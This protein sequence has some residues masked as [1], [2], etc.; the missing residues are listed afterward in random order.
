MSPATRSIAARLL[1]LSPWLALL[2]LCS[3]LFCWTAPGRIGYPDDEIVFQTTQSLVEQHSVEV[4]GIDKRTG[5]REG[6]PTGT[7]GWAPGRDGRRYGFFGQA[8]SVV[9][10]PMYLLADAT[11]DDIDERWRYAIRSDLFTFHKRSP[12]ADWLRLV[13]SLS[14]SLITPLGA[15]LLGLW[16]RALGHGPRASILTALCYALGTTA[17]PY[18]GSFLSE[19]LSV[20]VLLG[21]A[22]TI[23]RW[24]RDGR[25]PQL[26]LAGALAGLS[27]HV[28]VLNLITLPCLIGYALAP[29]LRA[30]GLR[31]VWRALD[32]RAWLGAT[33]ACVVGLALL[34]VSQWWRFGS[35]FETG[36]YDHYGHWVWPWRG[37]FT[38][39]VAPGRSL[40]IYSP[41]LLLGLAAW[42]ALRRRD[43]ETAM[44]VAGLAVT[45][46]VFVAC[47]SDWHGGWAIGP[48]YL[49]PMIPFLLVP[50]AGWLDRWSTHRRS[51]RVVVTGLLGLSVPFQAWLASHSVFQ[52]YWELNIE[53]GRDRYMG[54]ADWSLGSMP[55]VAFWRLQQPALEFYRAGNV[56]AARTS[57]QFDALGFGAWRLAALTDAD[58]LWHL[59]EGVGVAGGIAAAVLLGWLVSPRSRVWPSAGPPLTSSLLRR[60]AGRAPS[61]DTSSA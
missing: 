36:R 58:G 22:L 37:I 6:R 48:R 30:A 47:R 34:G 41:P 28:H 35:V 38:M 15:L 14:N 1:G 10:I 42:P 3:A 31:G 54:V 9:A 24:Q 8:L 5:E 26:W 18:A 25:A 61:T 51:A 23:T 40:L 53:H 43:P 11:V 52:I 59:L 17:W 56:A 46:L 39:L 12:S 44:F 60:P 55:P 2:V 4:Q 19:P 50:V 21:A 29:T 27:V 49:I 13:V 57:A 32:R 16:L 7:F 20:V 45:R 33:L